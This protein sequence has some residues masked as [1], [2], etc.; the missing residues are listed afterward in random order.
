MSKIMETLEN[1]VIVRQI[2]DEPTPV[3][4]IYRERPH[5]AL[6]PDFR[7]IIFNS[8]RTGIPQTY[9]ASLPENLLNGLDSGEAPQASSNPLK[10]Q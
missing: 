10:G 4:N 2:T 8:D 3:S 9:V 6:S 1:G 7:R 5:V